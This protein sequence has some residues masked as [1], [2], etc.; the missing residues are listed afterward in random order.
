[1][2]ER[3]GLRPK[4]RQLYEGL[5]RLHIK[6]GLGQLGL[7][8][9]TPARVR[10]WR[11][12]LLRDGL[13]EVTVA[14]AYRLLRTVMQTAV[15]DRLI[16]ANPCQ[17]KGA[18]VERSA[19]RPVLTV[20]QLY[21]LADAMP[22]H[23]RLLVLMAAFCSLRFGELAALTCSAVDADD[24]FVQIRHG[25][26]EMA[27]GSL[28][29]GAPKTSAG[30]RVV[31]IPDALLDDVRRHRDTYAA[32]GGEG[33]FF[34]GP[35]GGPLRRS[36]F[37]KYWRRAMTAAGI[38]GF[39]FHDLRHTGNT[40]VAQSGATLPDLMARMGHSSTRAASIYL[41]TNSTR[42]RLI[43][44][45]LSALIPR[46]DRARSGHEEATTDSEGGEA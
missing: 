28:V 39:H 40:W 1:M 41:H 34:A 15:D 30:R 26:V 32:K 24:G 6:P 27:N 2:S 4:T 37:Q 22:R 33:L 38:E 25:V 7:I 11:S 46:S 29:R 17:I 43:A 36:N 44:D 8:D 14:K 45:R 35:L 16:R 19:E 23:Y 13:G 21:A 5:V 10:T 31:G 42:D 9:I 3:A 18:A 12:G 20:T